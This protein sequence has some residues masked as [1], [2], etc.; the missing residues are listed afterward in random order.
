MRNLILSAIVCIAAEALAE[1][2]SGSCFAYGQI[3][4]R[5][6]KAEVSLAQIA[7][8]PN[9][10][11]DTQDAPALSPGRAQAIARRVLKRI[12]PADQSWRLDQ[13]RLITMAE[14]YWLYEVGF[15]REYPPDPKVAR[16]GGD[17]FDILVLMDGT[18]IEPKQV[19][20][21]H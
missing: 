21:P 5:Y 1:Q 4:G 15:W 3:D 12:I 13:V 9:W 14:T 20:P 7:K 11:P 16:F 2:P 17:R 10:S 19:P 18:A 8:T 6:F